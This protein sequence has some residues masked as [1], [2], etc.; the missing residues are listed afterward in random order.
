MSD[1][2][3]GKSRDNLNYTITI[4]EIDGLP[5]DMAFDTMNEIEA[6]LLGFCYGFNFIQIKKGL[7]K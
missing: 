7:H 4:N 5:I 2:Y 3:L 1:K 6:F